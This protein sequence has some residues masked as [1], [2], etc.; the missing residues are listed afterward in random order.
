MQKI[1]KNFEHTLDGSK[2]IAGINAYLETQESQKPL[3]FSDDDF[4]SPVVRDGREKKELTPVKG[5]LV[6]YPLPTGSTFTT[7]N[8]GGRTYVNLQKTH[9]DGQTTLNQFEVPYPEFKKIIEKVL[10]KKIPA[11]IATADRSLLGLYSNRTLSII[12]T[13]Q[14]ICRSCDV[15]VQWVEQEIVPSKAPEPVTPPAAQSKD[16]K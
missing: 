14:S 2:I 15:I 11:D 9:P 13:S 10:G 16:A 7:M 12:N 5:K 1:T 4:P 8:I 3:E 6:P